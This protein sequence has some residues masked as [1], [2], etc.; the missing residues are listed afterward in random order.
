MTLSQELRG[1]NL[2]LG[3]FPLGLVAYPPALT[4]SIYGVAQFRV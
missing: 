1:L 4:P 2:T 3:C